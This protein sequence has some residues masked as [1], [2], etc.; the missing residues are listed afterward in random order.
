[1]YVLVRKKGVGGRKSVVLGKQ[2]K[3]RHKTNHDTTPVFGP[4][5]MTLLS[6]EQHLCLLG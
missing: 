4:L 3:E 5:G 1:M 6:R 2:F